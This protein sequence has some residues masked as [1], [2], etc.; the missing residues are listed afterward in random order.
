MHVKHLS[1]DLGKPV[2]IALLVA[3]PGPGHIPEG[4][5]TLYLVLDHRSQRVFSL[6]VLEK[7]ALEM[8]P[9]PHPG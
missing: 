2:G 3:C 8:P 7:K 1:D 6:W 9:A 4:T 5:T